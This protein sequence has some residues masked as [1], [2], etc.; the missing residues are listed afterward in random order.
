[1]AAFATAVDIFKAYRDQ[2]DRL[3]KYGDPDTA[4]GQESIENQVPHHDFRP[5]YYRSANKNKRE[6]R[7]TVAEKE[8]ADGNVPRA[9]FA[10]GFS[11]TAQL[12]RRNPYAR[13]Y[14]TAIIPQK[15]YHLKNTSQKLN[16]LFKNSSKFSSN[17]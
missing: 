16:P 1:L 8:V 13:D 2:P 6:K 12:R 7:V 9:H 5:E 10:Y 3:P 11:H 17:L 14:L 4:I 15:L